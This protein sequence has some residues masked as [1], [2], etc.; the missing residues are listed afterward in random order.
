MGSGGKR[1][2]LTIHHNNL[3]NIVNWDSILQLMTDRYVCQVVPLMSFPCM[4]KQ[5]RSEQFAV[6]ANVC[7]ES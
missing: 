1:G 7:L 4:G 3:F 2:N 5:V 6:N